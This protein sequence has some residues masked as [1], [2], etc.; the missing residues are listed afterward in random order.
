MTGFEVKISSI[1]CLLLCTASF[2]VVRF[3]DNGN[4]S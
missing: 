1:D 2:S 4:E 3:A